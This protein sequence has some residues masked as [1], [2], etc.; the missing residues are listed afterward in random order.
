MEIYKEEKTPKSIHRVLK[1]FGKLDH[2]LYKPAGGKL[3]AATIV[4]D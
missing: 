2:Y 3:Y 4:F 1:F